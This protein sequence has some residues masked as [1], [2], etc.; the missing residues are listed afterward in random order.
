MIYR[1]KQF[2]WGLISLYKKID[3]DYIRRYLNKD[4]LLLFDKL[5]INDKH[6]SIRVCKDAI[7]FNYNL[8]E[9]E[10]VEE[11]KLGKSALLHDIGKS[12]L[13]LSLIDKSL[14]VVLHK[15]TKGNIRKYKGNK[16]VNIYYNHPKEG[17]EILKLKRYDREI[18]EVVRDHHKKVYNKN[19]KY[20][21][22][23]ACCD[24]K[25]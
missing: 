19:N 24:N 5:K 8:S 22:I 6:H 21:D 4:E 16:K 9:S 10:K 18:L 25:N 3:Y 12:V 2:I 15:I 23:I 17:Y 14:I 11:I 7:S 20:L 1:V 13:Y